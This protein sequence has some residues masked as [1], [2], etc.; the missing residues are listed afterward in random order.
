MTR[1]AGGQNRFETLVTRAVAHR[2]LDLEQAEPYLCEEQ[3]ETG[4]DRE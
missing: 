4:T 2:F 3:L 1:G